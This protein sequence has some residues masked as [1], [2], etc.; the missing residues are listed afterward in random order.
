MTDDALLPSRGFCCESHSSQ[1]RQVC[2]N[3]N[4][5]DSQLGGRGGGGG[6]GGG[7]GLVGE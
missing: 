4:K 5:C 2:V 6:G 3:E 7:G 1:K